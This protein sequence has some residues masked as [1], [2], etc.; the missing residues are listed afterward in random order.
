MYLIK[1]CPSCNNKIRFPIDK[2]KI[3]VRCSCGY[4]FIADP[5]NPQLYENAKFDIF[6]GHNREAGILNKINIFKPGF[7]SKSISRIINLKYELKNFRLLPSSEQNRI[8]TIIGIIVIIL[9]I[10]LILYYFYPTQNKLTDEEGV[11]LLVL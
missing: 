2:G 4:F 10:I 11:A 1:S 8:I 3:Q 5:D 7:I 9:L 6:Y